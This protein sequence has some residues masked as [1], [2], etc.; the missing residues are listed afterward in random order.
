MC[1]CTEKVLCLAHASSVPDRHAGATV[2]L[3]EAQRGAKGRGQAQPQNRTRTYPDS[4]TP[5]PEL[6][7]ANEYP[8]KPAA[9]VKQRSGKWEPR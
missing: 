4:H 6:M 7:A 3:S 5:E 9:R 1:T 2:C 8:E